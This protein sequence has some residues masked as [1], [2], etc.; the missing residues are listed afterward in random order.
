MLT[1]ILMWFQNILDSEKSV[2]NAKLQKESYVDVI[3]Q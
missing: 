3:A 2:E 1:A